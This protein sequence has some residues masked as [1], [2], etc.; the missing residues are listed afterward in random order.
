MIAKYAC[1]GL[2]KTITKVCIGWLQRAVNDACKDK[3][4]TRDCKKDDFKGLQK[5]VAIGCKG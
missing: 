5:M 1:R 3:K 2:Q 4:I